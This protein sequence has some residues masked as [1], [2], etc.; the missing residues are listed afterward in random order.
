MVLRV[1]VVDVGLRH[2][3]TTSVHEV[4]MFTNALAV[5]NQAKKN[6]DK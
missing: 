6:I 2:I 5:D 3:A 1:S 4:L